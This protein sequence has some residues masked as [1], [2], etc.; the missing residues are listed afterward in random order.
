MTFGNVAGFFVWGM[1]FLVLA[2]LAPEQFDREGRVTAPLV[3]SG[4]AALFSAT[5][6]AVCFLRLFGV[7]I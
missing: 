6:S 1:L 2:V 3:M 4:V 5:F 7:R